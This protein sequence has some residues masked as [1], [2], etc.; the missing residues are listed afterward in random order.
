M[1]N[2]V[3][4]QRRRNSCAGLVPMPSEGVLHLSYWA[5]YSDCPASR[6]FVKSHFTVL[7]VFSA[8]PLDCGYR[9]EEVTCL[10]SQHLAN[11]AY[12][13]TVAH[14]LLSP[15]P[16]CHILKTWSSVPC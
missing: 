8:L 7:T 4:Q 9:G 14:C 16:V 11:V 1:G 12:S 10:K 5:Q 6:H 13:Q 2:R 15:H 3:L